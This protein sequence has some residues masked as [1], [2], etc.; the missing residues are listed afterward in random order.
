MPRHLPNFAEFSR[1]FAQARHAE[2]DGPL[3]PIYRELVADRLTPVSAYARIAKGGGPSF[4]FENVIG[5]EKGGRFSFL[6]AGRSTDLPFLNINK[7]TISLDTPANLSAG[8]VSVTGIAVANYGPVTISGS[9]ASY[10]ITLAQPISVADRVTI[11]IGNA[12]IATYTRRV[13]VLPGDVNDDG[14]VDVRDSTLVRNQIIGISPPTAFGDI[15]GDG[16]VDT[17]DYNLVRGRIGTKL[18]S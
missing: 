13:D 4:L 2:G 16:T 5:G 9:G 10:T 7:F 1:L 18:P 3:V 14:V 12:Q 8:E 11:T 17:T 15:N 6:G